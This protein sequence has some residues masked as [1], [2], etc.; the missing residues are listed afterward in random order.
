VSLPSP[1]FASL[2]VIVSSPAPPTA[3]AAPAA[4]LP[5]SWTLGRAIWV[6]V[7][8][9]FSP[10]SEAMRDRARSLPSPSRTKPPGLRTV[11][12]ARLALTRTQPV[13]GVTAAP[14]SVTFT[15]VR[16]TCATFTSLVSP[17]NASK[18]TRPLD[19]RA[20]PA[21]AA[22][23]RSAKPVAATSAASRVARTRRPGRR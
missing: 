19:T 1:P 20:R 22:G 18:T 3:S 10:C 13:P 17:A 6:S 5:G 11:Q 8:L 7:S 15:V 16:P 12:R 14:L 4:T 2:A 21:S 9:P 23:G